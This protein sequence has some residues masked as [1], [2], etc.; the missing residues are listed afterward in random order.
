MHKTTPPEIQEVF[1][2]S[3]PVL[4]SIPANKGIV[5]PFDANRGLR[6]MT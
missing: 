3:L 4:P 2:F 1:F 5:N 6:S